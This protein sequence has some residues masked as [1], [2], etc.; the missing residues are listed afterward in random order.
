[1]RRIAALPL[2]A[3]SLLVTVA[4]LAPMTSVTVPVAAEVLLSQGCSGDGGGA[5]AADAECSDASDTFGAQCTAVYTTLCNQPQAAMCGL[6]IDV[7]TCIATGLTHCPCPN[8]QCDAGSC[9]PESTVTA[10]T[11]EIQAETCNMLSTNYIPPDCTAFT[12]EM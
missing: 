3:A 1:V 10:C 8:G 9:V 12:N 4:G 5:P 11:T 7:P 6:S 2:A